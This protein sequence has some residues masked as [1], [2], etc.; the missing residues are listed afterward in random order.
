MP[1]QKSEGTLHKSVRGVVKL[2]LHQVVRG[3]SQGRGISEGRG[4]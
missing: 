3:T 4:R 2:G 1:W